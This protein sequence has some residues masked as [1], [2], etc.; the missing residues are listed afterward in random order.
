MLIFNSK[1]IKSIL[2]R[3]G[4]GLLCLGVAHFLKLLG[5]VIELNPKLNVLALSDHL[6]Q[7]FFDFI[8]LLALWVFI[9]GLLTIAFVITAIFSKA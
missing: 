9:A 2:T 3:L 1:L 8:Y 5:G 4:G 6:S 7:F